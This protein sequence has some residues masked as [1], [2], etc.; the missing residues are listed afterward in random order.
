[1]N[2]NEKDPEKFYKES[3]AVCD[4]YE[5]AQDLHEQGVHIISNDEKTGIQALEKIHD[6][7]PAKPGGQLQRVE[8]NYNRHGTL[9]LIANFE[10]ATGKIV[11]PTIGPTRTE[12]DYVDHV[13]QTVATAPGDQWIFITDQL[14]THKSESLVRWTA[15]QCGL[16]IELGIKGKEGILKS[17]DSR[18]EFLSDPSHRIRFVYTPKHASW[19]NQVEIWF[20]IISRKLL[21]NGNFHSLEHLQKRIVK[22]IDFFNAVMAKPFKWTYKARP[23]TV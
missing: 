22:F 17:M 9:C 19:M 20:S 1:L 23:L 16:G 14:N 7:H 6:T 10:I 5:Q 12:K 18:Q 21:K 2:T 11:A 4:I 3:S 8:Y 15:D 13:A